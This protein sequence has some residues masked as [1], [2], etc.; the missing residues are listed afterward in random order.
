MSIYLFYYTTDI[1]SNNQKLVLFIF[2]LK[3][4]LHNFV[5]S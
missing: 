3:P 2:P 1:T 5:N 4:V